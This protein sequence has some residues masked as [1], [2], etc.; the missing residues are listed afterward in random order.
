MGLLY[1][2]YLNIGVQPT[3]RFRFG[4]VLKQGLLW[5]V[6]PVSIIGMGIGSR[7]SFSVFK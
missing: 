7:F 6:P 4:F 2:F 1:L 5:G 3:T